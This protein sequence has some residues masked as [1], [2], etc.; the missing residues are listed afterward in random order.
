MLNIVNVEDVEPIVSTEGAY[1]HSIDK[2]L[3]P[4]LMPRMGK[5]GMV[6]TR[7]PGGKSACPFHTHA[8]ADEVFFVISG[9]GV[10]RYGDELREIGP[11][12]CMSCPAGSGVAHQ[13]ANPF[14]EDLV[15]LAVGMND[16]REVCTYPDSGKVTVDA[17]GQVGYFQPAGY[18]DGEPAVP[19][20][21]KLARK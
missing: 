21:F 4:A 6:M 7:V 13:L 5:L 16:P 12:D 2:P 9:R 14:E 3:T 11:G 18:Y 10:F 8:F 17:L 1:W 15:Y 20:I 19:K